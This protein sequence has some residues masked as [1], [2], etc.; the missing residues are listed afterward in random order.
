[1]EICIHNT[2]H[3]L[4]ETQ[5]AAQYN[6]LAGSATGRA[7]LHLL[8]ISYANQHGTK[9]LLWDELRAHLCIHVHPEHHQ[10]SRL[11]R[12]TALHK[13]Y[14]SNAEVCYVD[15]ADYHRRRTAV[16]VVVNQQ[17]N[18][19]ASCSVTEANPEIGED[20]ALALAVA[21]T[22]APTIISDSKTAL[23]NYARGRISKAAANII[24]SKPILP[25]THIRLIWTPAARGS[26]YQADFE[27]NV[28]SSMGGGTGWLHIKKL[29]SIIDWANAH[30]QLLIVRLAEGNRLHGAGYIRTHSH[31]PPCATA[32]FQIHTQIVKGWGAAAATLQH[33]VWACPSK[34][35][36]PC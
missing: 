34:P 12:A 2:L 11:A 22:S 7:I 8:R 17:G 18:T 21:G 16:A 25:S 1:M 35:E 28:P 4:V 14:H 26:S 23:R 9:I 15:A 29:P 20:V 30:F 3:E 24:Q 31:T 5:R 36:T 33:M 32:T 10:E 6:R 27:D 13:Q 19:V